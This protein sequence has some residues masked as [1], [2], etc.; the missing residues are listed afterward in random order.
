MGKLTTKAMRHP[1]G[2]KLSSPART[3]TRPLGQVVTALVNGLP[4]LA[5]SACSLLGR[6]ACRRLV[7]RPQVLTVK[8]R[9]FSDISS[10]AMIAE[11]PLRLTLKSGRQHSVLLPVAVMDNEVAF[12]GS[13]VASERIVVPW[14]EI[15]S[16]EI[17]RH[18]SA[19]H[20]R[21]VSA[22]NP[23]MLLLKMAGGKSEN[24]S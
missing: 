5:E 11:K 3:A 12:A 17:E 22:D 15:V 13:S 2:G 16:L 20:E 4:A 24:S 14:S 10:A 23:L 21:A 6:V 9:S 18:G 1:L 19:P 7:W 8:A